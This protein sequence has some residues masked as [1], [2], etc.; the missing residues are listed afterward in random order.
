[1]KRERRQQKRVEERIADGK[2]LRPGCERSIHEPGG[3][4]GNCSMHFA[5]FIRSL[6]NR[7]LTARRRIETGAIRRG[8]ILARHE[9]TR[10]SKPE[11]TSV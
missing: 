3:G 9:I 6:A 1:M 5:R 7:S 2:C 8:E 4:R 11:R 10:L